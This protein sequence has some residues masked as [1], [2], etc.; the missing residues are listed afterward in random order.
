MVAHEL[1]SEEPG[2]GH[3]IHVLR[4]VKKMEVLAGKYTHTQKNRRNKR[5]I[6]RNKSK[7]TTKQEGKGKERRRTRKKLG[8]R[9]HN[10][11]YMYIE[12][13]WLWHNIVE[14]NPA[15]QFTIQL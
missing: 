10:R 7:S 14:R 9:Q 3:R 12:T 4:K 15:L 8:M 1:I 5:G 13:V 6:L 11:K 2:R